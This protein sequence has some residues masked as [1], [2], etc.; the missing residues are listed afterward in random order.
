VKTGAN[1]N[2]NTPCGAISSNNNGGNPSPV[3]FRIR[4]CA[5]GVTNNNSATTFFSVNDGP[6]VSLGAPLASQVGVGFS[7]L[8]LTYGG[9]NLTAAVLPFY[10][11]SITLAMGNL[12]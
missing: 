6:E 5:P 9:T 4:Y 10:T 2:S 11:K 7:D 1:A 8:F 12:A 3:S